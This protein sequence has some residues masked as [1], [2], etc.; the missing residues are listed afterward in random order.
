AGSDPGKTFESQPPPDDDKM[1]EDQAG[2]DPKKSH[3]LDDTY[4]FRDKFFNEKSTKDEPG[5]QNVDAKVISMVTVPIHQAF[6]SVPPLSTPIIDLSP[7]KSIASPIREPLS[8]TTTTTT[9]P[10]PPPPK[11]KAQLIQN[12]EQDRPE[13]VPEPQGASEEYDLERA[14]Q[15]NTEIGTDTNKTAE[16]NEGQARSDPGKT[17]ESQPPPDDDK[18]DEDQ[19]G[20]DPEKSHLVDE[21]DEEQDRPES[22]PKPQ[23]AGE[24]YDLERAIHMS[25]ES[26]QA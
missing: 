26:F 3:I 25:L 6:T 22:V 7:P 4:A 11:N 9:L 12:E 2:S 8:A 10:L 16:L 15:M 17:F 19:A 5:K 14:I 24:E 23:G 1:D 21:P 18:M 20:S 13:S